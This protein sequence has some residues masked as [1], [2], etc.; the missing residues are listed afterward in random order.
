MWGRFWAFGP[1][2]GAWLKF[3]VSDALGWL[4]LGFR[5]VF[6]HFCFLDSS[7]G[8]WGFEIQVFAKKLGKPNRRF[9]YACEALLEAL[10]YQARNPKPYTLTPNPRPQAVLAET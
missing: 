1:A 6:C 10:S 2:T 3:R 4:G 7:A 5:V 8:I 9:R